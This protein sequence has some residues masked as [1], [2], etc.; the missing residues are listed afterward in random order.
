MQPS[1]YYNSPG[2]KVGQQSHVCAMIVQTQTAGVSSAFCNGLHAVP[3]MYMSF[4]IC[5]YMS[6]SFQAQDTSCFPF[7]LFLLCYGTYSGAIG[8]LWAPNEIKQFFLFFALWSPIMNV[9]L[10]KTD[11]MLHSTLVYT[12]QSTSTQVNHLRCIFTIYSQNR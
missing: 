9:F 1:F 3:Q 8:L 5:P 2:Q 11:D 7:R 4:N 6:L 12:F 10:I